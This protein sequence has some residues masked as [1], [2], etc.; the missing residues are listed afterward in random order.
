MSR[1]SYERLP[2]YDIGKAEFF[3]GANTGGRGKGRRFQIGDFFVTAREL[4]ALI[5]KDQGLRTDKIAENLGLS[6]SG[7][8]NRLFYLRRANH[9]PDGSLPATH[10][11]I[12][13]A[14]NLGL[15]NPMVLVALKNLTK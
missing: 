3:R 12:Y 15:L 6:S 7:V 1:Q 13:K 14:E 11:V 4:E 8:R 10:E 9:K 2:Q 5:L